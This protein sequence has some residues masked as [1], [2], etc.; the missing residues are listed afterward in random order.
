MN[1]QLIMMLM[2]AMV[3][4]FS[5][6][7]FAAEEGG[8]DGDDPGADNNTGGDNDT[9]GD[10]NTGGDEDSPTPEDLQSQLNELKTEHQKELDRY[11]NQV[12]TLKKKNKKLEQQSMTEEEKLEARERELAEKEQELQLKELD[13]HRK[14]QIAEQGLDKRLAEFI[15]V[16]AQMSEEDIVGQVEALKNIQTALRDEVIEEMKQ[17]GTVISTGN[18]KNNKGGSIGAQLAKDKTKAQTGA[19]K[20]QKHYF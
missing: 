17:N 19:I 2:L 9:G 1:L 20:G 18:R 8:Q 4:L 7:S 12:G 10:D 15:Q 5:I 6:P 3:G 16:D 13:A 14:G 11:R